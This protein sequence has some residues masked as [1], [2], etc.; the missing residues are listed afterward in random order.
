MIL[1]NIYFTLPQRIRRPSQNS[2]VCI[3]ALDERRG[4]STTYYGVIDDIW[5]LHYGSNKSRFFGV[6]GSNTQKMLRW[7]AMG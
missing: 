3:E 6:V 4:Q 5:K 1:I 7:T 2:G